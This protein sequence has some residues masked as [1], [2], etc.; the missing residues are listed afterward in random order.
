MFAASIPQKF[1]IP[2][3]ANAGTANMR[4]IPVASQISVQPGAASLTDGFPPLNLEAIAAG[5]IPP[6]GQDMNG[7]LNQITLWN[8]WQAA[9]GPLTFDATFAAQIGGYPAGARVLSNSGHAIYESLQD[10]NTSDPNTGSALWALT[11]CTWSATAAQAGGSANHQIVTLGPAPTSLFQL[12]GIPLLIISSGTNTDAVTLNPNGLGAVPLQAP[13]GVPLG[14][15]ALVTGAPF[16]ATYTGSAFIQLAYSNVFAS[17]IDN[18]ALT[19]GGVATLHSLVV[20]ASS[21][22]QSSLTVAGVTQLEANLGVAGTTNLQESCVIAGSTLCQST[23]GVA[24]GAIFQSTMG[25]T[26]QFVCQSAVTAQAFNTSSD[27]R[28]KIA[29]GPAEVGDLI[30]KVPVYQGKMRLGDR[31]ED[32]GAMFFAHELA[33]AAPHAVTGEKD[34]EETQTVDQVSLVPYLWAEIKAL[35]ARVLALEDATGN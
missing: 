19:V 24:G 6:F 1:P 7:I 31:Y 33:E 16:I 9:G 17:L 10:N 26:G 13:G 28:L 15:G 18:G 30:D 11:S 2:W 29:F 8:Q 25:V 4:P 21:Q 14:S 22:L 27:Y 3:G 20:S 5:G 35:R 12:I 34:G 32:R 23:L